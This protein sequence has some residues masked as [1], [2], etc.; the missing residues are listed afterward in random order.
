MP[1]THKFPRANVLLTTLML[2]TLLFI[3]ASFAV[4]LVIDQSRLAGQQYYKEQ[5]FAIAEAGFE[6]Y[7]WHLAHVPDDFV[8]DIGAHDYRNK[9]GEIIGQYNLEITPPSVG[10]SVVTIK[11]TGYT[12][13]KPNVKRV[14]IAQ[15]GIPSYARYAVVSN[16]IM[17][18]GEG[19]EVFGPIH[20]NGGIRFDGLAHNV[21]TSSQTSY[22]DPDHDDTNPEKLEYGVHTHVNPP[23]GSGITNS[24]RPLEVPPSAMQARPDV[25]IAGRE[26]SVPAIDFNGITSDLSSLKIKSL[27]GG[28]HLDA[29]GGQGYH[30]TL[31]ADGRIDMRIVNTT[32][33]CQYRS[34]SSW[35]DM[36]YCSSYFNRTCTQNS[37]CNYCS[38]DVTIYC[39]N[40]ATCSSAGAGTCVTTGVSCIQ[41][42]HS[43]GSRAADQSSFTYNSVSSIGYLLPANGIIFVEDDV[44]IDGQ[45][46]NSRLTI[47]A[48]RE[49][50]ASGSANIYINN[51]LTYTNYNGADVIGL[52][53]QKNVLV[54][55][56]S[57][58]TIRVDAAIIGQKGRVGRPNYG[59]TG[60]SSYRVQPT[61]SPLPNGGGSENSCDDFIGR[62]TLT[63]Y[64]A[65]GTFE[66][67]G[68]AWTGTSFCG[69]T[70]SSGYCTR[71]LNFDSNLVY[72]PPPSFPTTGE[73]TLISY[74]EQ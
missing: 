22:D 46:N 12:L 21:V 5:A 38:G 8:G 68:F 61:G 37:N 40:N 30:L 18:F 23:P 50:L 6:Y 64:G 32:L 3:G 20:S 69:G 35:Y 47:V 60:Y 36:G 14:I 65:L 54:G 24:Y 41:S 10:S 48:A 58:N 28:I 45:I 34:G 4:R 16:S 19:T 39:A 9:L 49:P 70:N 73:Y 27:A 1:Q 29:S 2:T 11:S 53:A 17:R 44:W 13:K 71:N 31:R 52:I 55:Y 56:F 33:R 66:R 74:E 42:S 43:I 62:S 63:T 67:Y 59:F 57:L 26:I 25:F 7:R 51:N 15:M 72:A